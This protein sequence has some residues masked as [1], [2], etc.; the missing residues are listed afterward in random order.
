VAIVNGFFVWPKLLPTAMLLA[1]AAFL[2]TPLWGELRRGALSGL[3][4]ATLLSLAMLGHG[5]SVFGIVPLAAIALFR[6]L[7]DRRWLGGALVAALVLLVPWSAYQKY[8]EPPG[9]RLLK[10]MLAGVVEVDGRGTGEAFLDSYGEAGLGGTLHDKGENFVTMAGG[11]PAVEHLE[12]AADALSSGDLSAAVGDTRVDLFYNLLPSLGLFLITP[13][14][15]LLA[16]RRGRQSAEEWRLALA[17]YAVLGIGAVFWGLVM[18]GNEASRTVLHQ[19]SFLLPVLGLCA[20]VC[21]LRATFPRFAVWLVGFDLV[22][23]LLI[24]VPAID[25]LPGTGYSALAALLAIAGL[26]GFAAL[27]LPRRPRPAV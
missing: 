19:G 9:N 24:Y 11:A 1:A 23:M 16:R 14:A 25:P 15:M 27:S 4:V 13:F 5:S 18:F 22:L 17:C 8:G 3:L 6:G 7:P 2:L 21:G 12:D 26:A 20:G 10:Y